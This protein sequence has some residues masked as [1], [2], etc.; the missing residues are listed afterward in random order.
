MTD[1]SRALWFREHKQEALCGGCAASED[2]AL[3]FVHVVCIE[4]ELYQLR[5]NMSEKDKRTVRRT[6]TG[7]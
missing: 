6:C 2:E 1:C 7:S 3:M 5:G 4:F